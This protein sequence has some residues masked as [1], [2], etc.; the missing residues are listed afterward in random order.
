MADFR[1]GTFSALSPQT[2]KAEGKG[3]G[4][5]PSPKLKRP[6]RKNMEAFPAMSLCHHPVSVRAGTRAITV[7]ALPN[8]NS[9]RAL[10]VQKR[11]SR[12]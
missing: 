7:L 10:A 2:I 11:S 4:C 12:P 5:V 6:L 3:A 9:V 1:R 8:S